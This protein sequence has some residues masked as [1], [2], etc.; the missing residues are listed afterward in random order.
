MVP[1]L[2]LVEDNLDYASL[3]ECMLRDSWGDAAPDRATRLDDAVQLLRR[4]RYD[5]VILDLGLPD[6]AG[7]EVLAAVHDAAGDTPVV[8][9]TAYGNDDSGQE[10]LR[11]GAQDYLLKDRVKGPDLYQSIRFAIERSAAADAVRRSSERMQQ[12]LAG[13][14]D[15]IV[16]LGPDGSVPYISP[17]VKRVLGYDPDW[18]A[19]SVRSRLVHPEDVAAVKQRVRDLLAGRALGEP[20][21]FRMRH[22]DGSW[23]ILEAVASTTLDDA[24]LRGIVVTLRDVTD[25]ERAQREVAARV[26]QQAMLAELGRDALHNLDTET[27]VQQAAEGVAATLGIE[28]G[29]VM[30]WEDG[31]PVD[32]ETAL[33]RSGV[34][35]PASFLSAV[36]EGRDR[37]FGMLVAASL[38][39]RRFSADDIHLVQSVANLLAVAVERRRTD[40]EIRYQ[41]LHDS[42]TGLPNRTMLADRMS[43]AL[44]DTGRTGGEVA[45][46]LMD[47]DRFKEINDT[48]GHDIGDRVLCE[49]A[50]RLSEV[51][52][53]TDTVARLGGDEF[54]VLCTHLAAEEA[55]RVATKI[56]GALRPPCHVDGM[57]LQ[58]QASIGIAFA[59]QHGTAVKA[60]L[61]RAD[62]AMYRA[63]RDGSGLNIYSAENEQSQRP[64]PTAPAEL[65]TA[66]EQ[67]QLVLHYQPAVELGTG[68]V[69]SVEAL[70]RWQHP[71]HGLLSPDWFI[72]AAEAL[73]LM[74]PLT[75]WVLDHA[76]AE[77][78]RWRDDGHDVPVS[79]N[80]PSGTL[81]DAAFPD[82]VRAALERA[83]V[84][85]SALEVEIAEKAVLADPMAALEAVS[86]LCAIGVRVSLDD[87]GAGHASAT[88]LKHLP[89]TELKVD[90][91]FVRG[92]DYDERD[93]RTVRSVIDL[94][95]DLRLSVV[96]ENV[97]SAAVLRRLGDLGCDKVQGFHVAEPVEAARVSSF[98]PG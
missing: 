79:V 78:R 64:R 35:A 14:S 48:L 22:G 85:P 37:P 80:L 74:G 70:V 54:A 32:A 86:A 38:E 4:H 47:L 95:H 53:S 73:G 56:L 52:R 72:P 19:S 44:A 5:C 75:T 28:Y 18:L 92:M 61:K 81:V 1:K 16:V 20:M 10:A 97:E 34:V 40:E 59:P 55:T 39:P 12:L 76:L 24:D 31:T 65:R 30:E 68:R 9:L 60:L 58:V 67:D 11:N 82:A 17:S 2:L 3:V 94:A 71:T 88:Y 42:L 93:D 49:V 77:A 13:I 69:V 66:I 8:V 33:R 41:A 89:V 29:L 46:L 7:A 36:I 90:G 21:Q 57:L 23:R 91:L 63:K 45:L 6:G 25:R 43:M 87:V 62:A 26:A 98:W 50:M 51:V 27:L 83:G 96:A 84:P 15:V